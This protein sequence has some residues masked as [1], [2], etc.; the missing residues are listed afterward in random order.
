VRSILGKP[1]L[2]E[3]LTGT[4]KLHGPGLLADSLGRD[5]QGDEMVLT[6]GHTVIRV[7]D[8]LQEEPSVAP[9]IPERPVR[10][11]PDRQTA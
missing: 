7:A 2:V 11:T 1:P 10:Q 3:N 5:P 8:D 4:F 9:R 6:E